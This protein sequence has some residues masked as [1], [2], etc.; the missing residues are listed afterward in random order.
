MFCLS[1][2]YCTRS[3]R[4]LPGWW[5]TTAESNNQKKTIQKESSPWKKGIPVGSLFFMQ[6]WLLH[7][8][9][10]RAPCPKGFK[11]ITNTFFECCSFSHDPSG[12]TAS[13]Q[14]YCKCWGLS[15]GWGIA[16]K[17][18]SPVCPFLVIT[19]TFP[20]WTNEMDF[21][22]PQGSSLALPSLG[23]PSPVLTDVS[24]PAYL[25]V[26]LLLLSLCLQCPSSPFLSLVDMNSFVTQVGINWFLKPSL[27]LWI[28]VR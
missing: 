18:V 16:E 8:V 5:Q 2:P 27:T 24:S 14:V 11:C 20:S 9:G 4:E 25:S 23:G 10:Y 22:P 6:L 21:Q 28:W 19:L 3:M 26:P 13:P 17:K 12:L 1:A 7:G 15:Q